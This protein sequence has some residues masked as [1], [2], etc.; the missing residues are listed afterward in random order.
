MHSHCVGAA[1][2]C[3][4]HIPRH[5]SLRKVAAAAADAAA[6]AT[7]AATT[8]FG[9]TGVAHTACYRGRVAS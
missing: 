8:S 9:T 6:V 1:T 7:V 2:H 3:E 5:S 4:V